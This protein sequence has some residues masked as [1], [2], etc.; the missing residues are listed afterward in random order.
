MGWG[1]LTFV[2]LIPVRR[3]EGAGEGDS[4][5]GKKKIY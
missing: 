1:A 3:L 2:V 5:E 4:V